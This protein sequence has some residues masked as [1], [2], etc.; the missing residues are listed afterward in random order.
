MGV[1]RTSVMKWKIFSKNLPTDLNLNG[2]TCLL[3][4]SV[5]IGSTV[6]ATVTLSRIA[7]VSWDQLH[8]YNGSGSISYQWYEDLMA[9]P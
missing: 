3:L 9:L 6:I 2:P 4:K 8:Y 7:T 1:V 5:G